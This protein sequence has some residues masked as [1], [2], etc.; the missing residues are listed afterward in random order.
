[1]SRRAA[2]RQSDLQRALR[3]ALAVDQGLCVEIVPDGTI[4][5]LRQEP[6]PE[7]EPAVPAP[8]QTPPVAYDED[9]R[10]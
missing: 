1:M 5:I 2:F 4:R 9:F 10:L 7:P 6:E 3:A 8:A